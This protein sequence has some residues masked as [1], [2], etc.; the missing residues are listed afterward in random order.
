VPS[1]KIIKIGGL[2]PQPLKTGQSAPITIHPIKAVD[3]NKK[4]EPPQPLKTPHDHPVSVKEEKPSEK[5]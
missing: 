4:I 2:M 5:K 1:R 3:P